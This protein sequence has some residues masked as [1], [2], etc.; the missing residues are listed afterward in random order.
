MDWLLIG[1][2]STCLHAAI[3]VADKILLERYFRNNWAYPFFTA[4]FLG[5]YS[6]LILIFRI[7]KGVFV[8]P[9]IRIVFIALLPGF[10]HYAAALV[11]TRALR[12]A[13]ASTVFG[14]SQINPLFALIWGLIVFGNV[15]KPLNY[16]GVIILVLSAVFLAWE[17]PQQ[18]FKFLRFNQVLYLVILGTFIRSCSD[19][20]VKISVTEL[21]FWDAFALS[22]V[23]SLLPAFLLLSQPRIRQ[24]VIRPVISGGFKIIGLAGL[25]EIFALVNLILL[26]LAF[27]L[28]PLA[29]VSAT[30]ATLPLFILVITLLLNQIHKGMVPTTETGV[31]N[32]FR[33]LLGGG[34]VLG[35]LLIYV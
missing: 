13:D 25:V 16:L 15:Y 4:L 32:K 8:A 26:T 9:D 11:T 6:L 21:A 29:L 19:L 27:S 10:L 24:D 3:S 35:V 30:Q 20:F 28:G 17:K 22:R 12:K 7:A 33:F 1:I 5:I 14:L 18:S 31:S 34:I 2:S 23:G